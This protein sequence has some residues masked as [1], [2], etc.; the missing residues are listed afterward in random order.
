M[1]ENVSA[2]DPLRP[3]KKRS[4]WMVRFF[5]R[6]ARRFM[7]KNFHGVRLSISGPLPEL[8]DEPLIVVLNH[9][10]WWDPMMGMVLA[11]LLPEREHFI[12]IDAEA[13]QKYRIFEKVGFFGIEPGTSAGARAFLDTAKHLLSENNRALWITAQGKFTDARE[14][15][16]QLMSGVGHLARSLDRA[17]LLPLALEYTFWNERYPEALARFGA[18]IMAS[19]DSA[20][21]S[22]DWVTTIAEGLTATQDALALEAQSR[23][24]ELF[25][26]LIKG[27]TGIGGA[28]DLWRRLKSWFRGKRFDPSH[29]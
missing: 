13:L 4:P 3:L 29:S 15:P 8:P 22:R 17:I 18:P 23:D 10:S 20:L 1:T 26:D 6:Y 19:G 5:M 16:V 12:P 7:R 2:H 24:P 27:E 28:Y 21:S 11:H 9:P 25:E 14:R